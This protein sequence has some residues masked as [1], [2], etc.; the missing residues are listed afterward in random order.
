[1]ALSRSMSATLRDELHDALREGRVGAWGTPGNGGPE[2]PIPLQEWDNMFMEFSVVELYAI[3][4]P[5]G[6]DRQMSAWERKPSPRGKIHC[7]LNVRFAKSN[8]YREFP[9]RVWPRRIDYVQT[10]KNQEYVIRRE[11]E[12]IFEATTMHVS[13]P[14]RLAS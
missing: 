1:M 14:V 7:Y 2:R 10:I 12:A 9:L 8:V 5:F 3:P 4:W 6:G 13:P 11:K